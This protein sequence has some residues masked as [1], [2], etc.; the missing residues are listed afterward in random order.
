[1]MFTRLVLV[2]LVALIVSLPVGMPSQAYALLIGSQGT[3]L[4]PGADGGIESN[5][6]GLGLGAPPSTTVPLAGTTVPIVP[7]PGWIA[8]E[9]G[10]SW[11][12]HVLGSGSPT[13]PGLVPNGTIVDFR[14]NFTL[15]ATPGGGKWLGTLLVHADDSTSVWIDKVLLFPEASSIGNGYTKCSDTTI[16]C[17]LVTQ[18]MFSI[19]LDPGAHQFD[20]LTAQRADVS[21]GLNYAANLTVPEP[22]TTLLLGMGL[23]GVGLTLR[24]RISRKD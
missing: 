21:Y 10:T 15:P 17:T 4:S 3:A 19:T 8:A 7:N 9:P 16:G 11:V 6:L 14:E 22:G 5:D 23:I 24:R 12:S 20:F 13:A 1:M 2:V 18:G